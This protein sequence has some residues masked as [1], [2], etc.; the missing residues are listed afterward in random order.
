LV[1]VHTNHVIKQLNA[2]NEET[3]AEISLEAIETTEAVL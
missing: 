2:F 3:F 1:H